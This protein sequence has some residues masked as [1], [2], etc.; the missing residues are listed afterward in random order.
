MLS[1][2]GTDSLDGGDGDD[3]LEGGGKIDD[4]IGGD[5][6]DTLLGDGRDGTCPAGVTSVNYCSLSPTTSPGSDTITGGAGNDTING[7]NGA[8]NMAGNSG[9]D[10]ITG[11]TGNDHITGDSG[12]DADRRRRGQRPDLRRQRQRR[13]HAGPG[14]DVVYTED[15]QVDTVICGLGTDRAIADPEDNVSMSCELRGEPRQRQTTA[16]PAAV[17]AQERVPPGARRREP[18]PKAGL[19]PF[20]RK[21]LINRRGSQRREAERGQQRGDLGGDAGDSADDDADDGVDEAH[22]NSPSR[23]V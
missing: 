15:G 19:S 18:G 22:Q 1:L 4:L 6:D 7:G 21:R 16:Q 13:R 10:F 12:N 17:A 8:N 23:H 5:G 3:Y 20:M 14:N 11:G 2:S 9:A